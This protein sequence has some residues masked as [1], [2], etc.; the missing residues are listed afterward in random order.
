MSRKIKPNLE[1][2]NDPNNWKWGIFYFN[3]N[4]KRIFPPKRSR[5]LGWTI[6][7]A[8]PYS[9]LAFIAILVGVV[10]IDILVQHPGLLR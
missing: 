8:N 9:V 5:M 2:D 6:N 1:Q 7:F 10:Y 4:D 3:R